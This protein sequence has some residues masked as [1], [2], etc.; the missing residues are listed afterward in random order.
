MLM[1]AAY[2][3]Q[4]AMV[5]ML[6]QRGASVN[7]QNSFGFTA[8]MHAAG[9]GHTTTMQALLDAKADASLQ[10]ND[11]WTAL[12]WAEQ[13]KHT[14]T[15]QLLRQ[16]A[17]RL[18]AEAEARVAASPTHAAAAADAMAAEL[19][20]EEAAEK[21]AAAKG[22]GKGKKKKSKAVAMRRP[23]LRGW[24]RAAA[25]MHAAAARRE[26]QPAGLRRRHRPDIRCP[27]RPH[28]DHPGAAR[29]QGRCLAAGHQ[30]QHGARVGRV[31]AEHRNSAVAAAARCPN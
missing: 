19:L 24:T 26:R 14:A 6:L 15:A 12:T 29:R 2:G 27:Q 21:E 25:W 23:W 1:A 3:G 10:D 8:L 20:G 7:L 22:K 16:H 17:K 11:G 5:R 31:E 28:H 30:R 13:R 9:N 4:A 18:T